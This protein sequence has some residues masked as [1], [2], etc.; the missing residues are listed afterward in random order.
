MR[1]N[2][3]GYSRFYNRR[4]F[5]KTDSNHN[6]RFRIHLL[7]SILRSSQE[8][9]QSQ[10]KAATGDTV[11]VIKLR[12]SE[13]LGR[14]AMATLECVTQIVETIHNHKT[15]EGNCTKLKHEAIDPQEELLQSAHIIDKVATRLKDDWQNLSPE[16]YKACEKLYNDLKPLVDSLAVQNSEP[17]EDSTNG[18]EVLYRSLERLMNTLADAI[19]FECISSEVSNILSVPFTEDEVK[20]ADTAIARLTTEVK[21]GE[22]SPKEIWARFDAVRD[23]ITSTTKPQN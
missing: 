8:E 18:G 7:P 22:Y 19:E 2:Q 12:I 4:F 21:S 11:M 23:R 17:R 10:K 9:V 13:R 20:K 14:T 15:Q 16:D 6:R 3:K 5:T 1:K